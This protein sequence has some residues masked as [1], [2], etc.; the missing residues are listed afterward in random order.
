M[1]CA[2]VTSTN[3][4]RD[5]DATKEV[6][7][8]AGAPSAKMV[9]WPTNSPSWPAMVCGHLPPPLVVRAGHHQHTKV[10]LVPEDMKC[11]RFVLFPLIQQSEG[12]PIG[13]AYM[14]H[15][16]VLTLRR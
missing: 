5:L 8:G 6:T 3:L 15:Y 12:A 10:P 2:L 4:K 9:G 1:S 11:A 16:V 13:H 7:R 14:S